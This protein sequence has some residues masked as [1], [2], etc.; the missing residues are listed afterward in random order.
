MRITLAFVSFGA[1]LAMAC[2][3][4]SS[5]STPSGDGGTGE[6]GGGNDGGAQP[7]GQTTGDGGFATAPHSPFPPLASHGKKVLATPHVV[8]ITYAG[9]DK[10]QSVED[11]GAF[12]V[13]SNWIVETGKDYGVGKGT[14][15]AA[16]LTTA[17][18]AQITDTA[19]TNLIDQKIG[20]G[21]LP[22]LPATGS[23]LVY[24][25][26]F[27]RGTQVDEGSG[28]IL[29][30]ANGAVG[31]HSN[32][33]HN[34]ITF[35]Y[36]VIPDCTGKL[37]DVTSTSSH[38]IIEAASD[39]YDM[40]NDGWFMDPPLPS[41]WYAASP[42]E[43]ADLCQYEADTMEGPWVVQRVWSMT[44][45]AAGGSPC[46]PAVPGEIYFNTSATPDT[47][48]KVAKGQSVSFTIT[49]WSTA[50]MASWKLSIDPADTTDFDPGATLSA[51]TITNGGTVTVTLT[52]PTSATSGQIGAAY[53]SSGPFGQHYWPV[54]IQVK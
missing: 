48:Q 3:S 5:P 32:A 42:N 28:K 30:S 1:A 52:A 46:V 23:Q 12:I 34:G 29:C 31:Y 50:E 14:H 10:Q 26:Y 53:V 2:G 33:T 16:R 36:A 40:P 13:A 6:D 17:A 20:D 44:A 41:L 18:P 15:T 8:T 11:F 49:G 54:A 4:S 25:I 21:T 39:P 38:E 7:D 35:A 43:N 37:G 9:Y 27:P 24:M 22:A 19:I 47:V 51:A 45:A